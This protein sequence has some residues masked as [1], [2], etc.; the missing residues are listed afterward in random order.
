MKLFRKHERGYIKKRK[1]R[2]YPSTSYKIEHD[3]IKV[4]VALVTRQDTSFVCCEPDYRNADEFSGE[5]LF[6]WKLEER[7][8]MQVEK[9]RMGYNAEKYDLTY[10][11]E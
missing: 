4:S 6:E 10:D 1:S 2:T 5:L 11:F 3:N 8:Y 7:V 9:R